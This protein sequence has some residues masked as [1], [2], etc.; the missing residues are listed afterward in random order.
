ML[1]FAPM[2]RESMHCERLT[3]S[4][5]GTVTLRLTGPLEMETVPSFL[6]V[7][8]AENSPA[9]ILDLTA[10][11]Y[12]DSAGVGALVQMLVG[13]QKSKRKMALVN[14]NGRVR[15]VLEVTRVETQFLI[16]PTVEEAEAK[17]G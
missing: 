1:E 14:P 6:K 10:V 17:L 4:R 11:S 12:L 8:R 15:A 2:T 7:V 13:I 16:A 5:P 9:V 3:G